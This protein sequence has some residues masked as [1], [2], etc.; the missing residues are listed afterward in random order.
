MLAG[1]DIDKCRLAGRG[2]LSNSV[3]QTGWNDFFL[4]LSK[5]ESLYSLR[6]FAFA[7]MKPV[8]R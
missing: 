5:P 4:I 1:V 3:K 6:I 8:R 7:I 2:D